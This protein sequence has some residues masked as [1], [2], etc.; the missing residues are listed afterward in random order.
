MGLWKWVHEWWLM[1]IKSEIC[2]I[3]IY[4]IIISVLGSDLEIN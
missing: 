3:N 1:I 2:D 4:I